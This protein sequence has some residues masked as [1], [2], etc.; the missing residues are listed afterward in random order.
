MYLKK[1]SL[2]LLVIVL[3]LNS[4]SQ[5]GASRYN[6]QFKF[7]PQKRESVAS[8]NVTI[9]LLKPIFIDKEISRAGTPWDD[10]SIKMQTDIEEM[11]LAKGFK[12]RGPF[13]T[14]DEMLFNDKQNSDFTLEIGIDLSVDIQRDWKTVLA[15]IGSNYLRVKKGNVNISSSVVMTA[16]SNFSGEKLWK[17]NIQLSQKNFSYTG[18]AKWSYKEITFLNEFKEDNNLFNPISKQLEIIYSEALTVLWNQF[19]VNE[20]KGVANESKKEKA[21]QKQ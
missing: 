4:F 12:V 5:K 16:K 20:M 8:A 7:E 17:K 14:R 21:E 3:V 19:D 6:P 10:F 1:I 2:S 15:L 11:L 9:A 13:N 18:D